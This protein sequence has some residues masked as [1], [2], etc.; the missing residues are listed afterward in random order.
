[1]DQQIYDDIEI[2]HVDWCG[3]LDTIEV[4]DQEAHQ[5]KVA[6]VMRWKRIWWCIVLVCCIL[7]IIEETRTAL[8]VALVGLA[9][10]L[11]ISAG[12][13]WALLRFTPGVVAIMEKS[14]C[15]MRV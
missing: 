3:S 7:R 13:G 15:Q 11:K 1:M 14:S 4:L 8:V 10:G 2:Q 12:M 9:T 6:L 5:P